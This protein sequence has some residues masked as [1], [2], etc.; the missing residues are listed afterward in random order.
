MLGEED[1]S[2]NGRSNKLVKGE[3][4]TDKVLTKAI[5]YVN[6]DKTR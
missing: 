3:S 2:M 5:S 1:I 4:Y 6:K